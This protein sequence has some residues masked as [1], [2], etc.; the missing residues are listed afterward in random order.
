MIWL[1]WRQMR[2]QTLWTAGLVVA[3][4]VYLLFLAGDIREAYRINI[5]DCTSACEDAAHT[6]AE[7]FGSGLLL[8]GLLLL[9]A[10]ALIGAFWAA[11][12]IT[13]E[14]ETGTHR[15]VW[16]QSVTRARWLAVK[17]ALVGGV[18]VLFTGALSLLLTWAAGPFDKVVDS[19][20]EPLTFAARDLAPFGYALLAFTLGVVIGVLTRKTL[21]A[22][23][24]T[25]VVFVMFQL[26]MA[27]VL[28]PQ[29]AEPVTE[30]IAWDDANTVGQI[31]SFGIGPQGAGVQGY[32]IPGAWVVSEYIV[33][34]K[35]DGT[36]VTAEDIEAC[37]TVGGTPDDCMVDLGATF[38]V[39]YQPADRYWDFQWIEFGIA[40]V[41]SALLAGVAFWRIPRG[42]N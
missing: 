10:P 2:A 36:D 20:F 28:R 13:R 30:T 26:V 35:A 7:Q 34:H 9:A 5:T 27:N 42:L 4:A 41:L 32:T 38:D 11:P 31:D 8:I 16:N 17:L 3:A 23:A 29:F 15:L 24:V 18:S 6:L 33:V 21:V 19:R 40:A 12:L 25:L 1:T 14:L 22:M 37:D 39:T